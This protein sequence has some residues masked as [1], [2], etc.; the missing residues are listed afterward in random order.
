MLPLAHLGLGTSFGRL[1][2]PNRFVM[3]LVFGIFLPDLIDKPILLAHAGV[4]SSPKISQEFLGHS[5][6]PI[7]IFFLLSVA[8]KSIFPMAI[9][10]GMATHL[11]LDA[12]ETWAEHTYQINQNF[13]VGFWTA[14]GIPYD[15]VT[16]GIHGP[17]VFF[18]EGIG[19]IL[20]ILQVLVYLLFLR[21]R[22]IHHRTNIYRSFHME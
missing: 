4:L 9:A 20:I 16:N 17:G 7:F 13:L 8:L 15:S 3:S 5:I 10:I 14:I 2:L 18:F 11:A 22:H 6:A 19:L 21:S 12:L 1:F